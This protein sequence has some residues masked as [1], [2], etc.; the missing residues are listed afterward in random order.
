MSRYI[1]IEFLVSVGMPG[2]G[3]AVMLE[4]RDFS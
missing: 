1:H 3:V 4:T 2:G